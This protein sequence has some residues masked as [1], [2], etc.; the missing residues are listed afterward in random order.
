MKKWWKSLKKDIN[1][2]VGT[3]IFV[4]LIGLA[5]GI[6][7][8]FGVGFI[9]GFALSIYNKVLERNFLIPVFIFVGAL[10][11]RFALFVLF[12]SIIHTKNYISL[13]I[14][15]ILFFIMIFMGFRIRNGKF[16]F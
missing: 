1:I 16:R 14:L 11:I 3:A 10:I 6:D 8:I 7:W 12:P 5:F 2:L 15:V 13:G 4:L 9:F